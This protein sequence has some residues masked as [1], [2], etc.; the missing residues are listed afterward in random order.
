MSSL[1]QKR[2]SSFAATSRRTVVLCIHVC[3][4]RAL[5]IANNRAK[6]IGAKDLADAKT[7]IRSVNTVCSMHDRA[8]LLISRSLLGGWTS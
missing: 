1:Q 7:M 8:M 6:T 3:S 2:Q 4:N 5:K